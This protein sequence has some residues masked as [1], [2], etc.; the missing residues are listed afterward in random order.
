MREGKFLKQNIDRWESY[1]APTSDLDEQAERLINLIDDLGYAKTFYPNSTTTQYVNGLA[2]RQFSDIYLKARRKRSQF[3]RFFVYELPYIFGKY[4]KLYLFSFLFF[5]TSIALAAVASYTDPDFI[6]N[7]LG[8]HYVNETEK[9][10]KDGTP[11]AIYAQDPP[12][13]MFMQ[14]AL[15]NVRVSF[16]AYVGGVV[17]GLPTL[18]LLFTNGLM[19]G[20][21][22]SMC[23]KYGVGWDSLMVVWLHGTLEINAIVIAGFAGLMLGFGFLFPGT[24]T[25]MHSLKN[26]ARASIKIIVAMVPFF[27]GAAMIESYLTRYAFAHIP[28]AIS[29][30]IVALSWIFVIGYFMIWPRIISRRGITFD[31]D[32]QMYIH[33]E[34]KDNS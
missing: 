21:F 23:F 27:I 24:Y 12:F 34:K 19:V 28:A 17:V 11:F 30:G 25:R 4:H 13:K 2:G 8:E 1:D 31:I 20:A 18:Y 9:N 14:I 33:G 3:A 6:T 5:A 10:V 32:G 7:V 15:N 16:L 22:H 26:H 29:I